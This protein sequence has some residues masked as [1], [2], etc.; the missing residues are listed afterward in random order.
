MKL[1]T[2]PTAAQGVLKVG[3][4]DAAANQVVLAASLNTISFAPAANYNGPASFTYKVTDSS[5]EES[6]A[7]ATVTVT[8]SAVNDLPVASAIEKT[9]DEDTALTFAASDFTDAFDDADNHELK[10]VKL[11]TLPT[12]AQGVLKVGT[13][14]AT[15]D[16][17]VLAASLN[18]ISFAPAANYNGPGQLH[19]QGDRHH[20]R[21]V[22]GGGDGDGDGGAV[23]DAPGG[24]VTID[25]TVSQGEE[26]T[27]NTSAVT[28]ADRSGDVLLPVGSGPWPGT[29][30]A[31]SGATSSTYTLVQAD[32]GAT[33]TVTVSWTDP[34][35]DGGE[36]DLDGDGGGDE[37]Q[38]RAGRLGDDRR[39]GDAGPG[40]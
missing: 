16:Q 20:G 1:V 18:T 12:A 36:P 30:T 37:R 29:E 13:S 7:A 10:S 33:I 8:V 31:I 32:V 4:S 34:R 39:H 35:R 25:G 3:T 22:C 2:L 15:A 28:D 24:S 26:L 40:R 11:V 17:V 9:T 21:G 38:R 5:G 27:A 23:N 19:L 14:A 6:A